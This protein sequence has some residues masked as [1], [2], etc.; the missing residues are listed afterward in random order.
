M[1]CL[2]RGVIDEN[3]E[4]AELL[5]G[6]VDEFTAMRRIRYIAWNQD[7]PPPRLL[8]PAR[9][10]LGVIMFAKI[11]NQ[12]IGAFAGKGNRNR[13]TDSGI[14]AGDQ[15][16]APSLLAT[17]PIRMLTVIRIGI[18]LGGK[19]RTGLLLAA[20]RG[21]RSCSLRIRDHE[22]LIFNF[23]LRAQIVPAPS[24]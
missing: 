7:R 23:G 20:E 22:T 18:H 11:R 2:E 9:G 14:G 24:L 4:A 17:A 6:S 21:T 8:D 10:L 12:Q 16:G 19:P 1:A 5:N 15:C 13:P 3:V